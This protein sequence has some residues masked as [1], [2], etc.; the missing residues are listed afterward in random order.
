MCIVKR[1]KE[2]QQHENRRTHAK[3]VKNGNRRTAAP[4]CQ[5]ITRQSNTFYAAPKIQILTLPQQYDKK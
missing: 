4:D 2:N 1:E 3:H 5:A